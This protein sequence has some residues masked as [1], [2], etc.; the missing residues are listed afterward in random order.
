[1]KLTGAAILVS[2]GTKV[3]QA[4][5][6][7]YPY[8]SAAQTASP[9]GELVASRSGLINHC[10]QK[11]EIAMADT[12]LKL[13]QIPMVTSNPTGSLNLQTWATN[14][15][16]QVGDCR[17]RNGQLTIDENGNV[18][19]NAEVWVHH[20]GGISNEAVLIGA[21]T[22]YDQANS[23]IFTIGQFTSPSL[24][25]SDEP[26]YVWNQTQGPFELLKSRF[27]DIRSVSDAPLHS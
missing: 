4:A 20:T 11:E 14:A 13:S 16:I 25:H 7:A 21:I 17:I 2:H 9:S 19:W 1:M 8:R 12:L 3:L 15:Q 27:R 5:P 24:T 6:A 22:V 10:N 18:S 23:P 26:H